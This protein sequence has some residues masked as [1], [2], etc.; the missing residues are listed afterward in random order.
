VHTVWR[1]PLN[2]FGADLLARHYQES[3]THA[4]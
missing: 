4:H 3:H 2:D 1:D